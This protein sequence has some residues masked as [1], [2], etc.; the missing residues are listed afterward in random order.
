MFTQVKHRSRPAPANKLADHALAEY[1]RRRLCRH[2]AFFPMELGWNDAQVE[3]KW[4]TM[5]FVNWIIGY[6]HPS[7]RYSS[8]L[9][10]RVLPITQSTIQVHKLD[11]KI[12]SSTFL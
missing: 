2:G 12:A 4:D 11:V 7:H 1:K 9:E 10:G 5:E 3:G 8:W 6:L